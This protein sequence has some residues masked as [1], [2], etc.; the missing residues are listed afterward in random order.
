MICGAKSEGG[1]SAAAAWP[2]PA[3]TTLACKQSKELGS[4]AQQRGRIQLALV[5]L[6]SKVKV[7]GREGGQLLQHGRIQLEV[8]LCLW[9]HLKSGGKKWEGLKNWDLLVCIPRSWL[10]GSANMLQVQK[11]PAW[12]FSTTH[13]LTKTQSARDQAGRAPSFRLKHTCARACAHVC[14]RACMRVCQQT[15]H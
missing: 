2:Q 1:G 12:H 11:Q 10:Q 7:R 3:R 14:A 6:V 13:M 4:H 5:W 9:L 15:P 8:R